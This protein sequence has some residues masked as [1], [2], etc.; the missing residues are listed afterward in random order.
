MT[1]P[2]ARMCICDVGNRVRPSLAAVRPEAQ[3][4]PILATNE[5]MRGDPISHLRAQ[6]PLYTPVAGDPEGGAEDLVERQLNRAGTHHRF[7]TAKDPLP[8]PVAGDP[9]GGPKSLAS[10]N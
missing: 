1:S 3:A 7:L 9:D 8:T 6:R 2:F 10:Q 5:P 4:A